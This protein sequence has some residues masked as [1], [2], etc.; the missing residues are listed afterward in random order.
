MATSFDPAP[1][2]TTPERSLG[3]LVSDAT[4]DL[5]T[6]VRNEVALAKAEV[7][8]DVKHAGKGGA[9]L[10]V[11][12][13]IALFALHLLLFAAAWGLVA[14]GLDAWLAF[15]IVGVVLV[16]IALA[17]AVM[18]KKAMQKMQGGPQR[19]VKQA[20]LTAEAVKPAKD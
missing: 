20:K 16:I 13:V 3:Q 4:T 18:G 7:S 5:Q 11:A 9:M 14:A 6:I 15:L 1:L 10:A 2:T 17:L 19:A 8:R 12:A